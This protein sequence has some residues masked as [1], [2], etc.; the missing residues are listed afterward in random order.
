MP[1][2]PAT[3]VVEMHE[4][5]NLY[6][7]V[8]FREIGGAL[9]TSSGCR[10]CHRFR[11]SPAAIS[12]SEP[13]ALT[14]VTDICAGKRSG[15]VGIDVPGHVDPALLLEFLQARANG[16]GKCGCR[17]PAPARPRC[18][19]PARR[20]PARTAPAVAAP[21]PIG[22]H[23][24]ACRVSPARN[25]RLITL[26]M[27][28]QPSCPLARPNL[29]RRLVGMRRA[30]RCAGMSTLRAHRPA[31]LVAADGASTSST[32]LAFS[33]GSD[34]FEL[35]VR[36]VELRRLAIAATSSWRPSAM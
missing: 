4:I 14:A 30:R 7:D 11:R 5:V 17:R 22:E 6:D 29:A 16:S 2:S 8:H 12:A 9:R 26:S 10:C 1:L 18:G 21:P 15:R 35:L 28:N 27:L 31:Q 24:R 36:I 32:D 19:R 33:L 20:R 25:L 13:G 23:A 3:D 34:G